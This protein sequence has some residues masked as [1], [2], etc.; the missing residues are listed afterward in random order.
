MK[1]VL[2]DIEEHDLQ[3]ALE[4]TITNVKRKPYAGYEACSYRAG[5][6]PIVFTGV[7]DDIFEVGYLED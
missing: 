1:I 7:T 6:L 4:F 2:T 3:R 5:R